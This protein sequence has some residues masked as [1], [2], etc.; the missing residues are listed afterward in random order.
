MTKILW[1][2]RDPGVRYNFSL[3][4]LY[5]IYSEIGESQ[6][7]AKEP[8]EK[9]DDADRYYILSLS[10]LRTMYAPLSLSLQVI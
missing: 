7:G 6:V 3:P 10:L 8:W 4:I 1:A 9:G 5:N 2:A